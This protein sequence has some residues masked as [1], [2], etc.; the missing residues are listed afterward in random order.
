VTAVSL[1]AG[2]WQA[3]TV[4]LRPN[5][6]AAY[7]NLLRRYLLPAFDPM[8]L[9]DLDPLAVRAWLAGMEA[10]G[11]GSEHARQVL[12]VAVA[13]PRARGGGRLPVA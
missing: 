10:A 1:P 13:H 3:T 9:A 11:V 12:P 4:N 2:R 7:T 8:P 5:T 6:R